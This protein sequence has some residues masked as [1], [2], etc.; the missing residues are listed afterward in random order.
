MIA[1]RSIQLLQLW[2]NH[3]HSQ[4]VHTGRALRPH[5][6]NVQFDFFFVYIEIHNPVRLSNA[7]NDKPFED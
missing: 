1:W 2:H 5:P 6:R 3:S 4:T 7:L